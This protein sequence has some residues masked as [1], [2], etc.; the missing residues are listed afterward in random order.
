MRHA[1]GRAGILALAVAAVAIGAALAIATNGRAASGNIC[2]VPTTTTNQWASCVKQFVLPHFIA[3]GKSALS[4]TKFT[5]ESGSGG[6]TATHLVLAVDLG[7]SPGNVSIVPGTIQLYLNGVALAT[8]GCTTPTSTTTGDLVLSCPVGNV[9][10]GGVA[11]MVVEVTTA[12]NLQLVGSA[13][14]GE[15]PGNPS[16]PPNDFQQNHDF[17]TVV[18]DG[19]A[20]G[21]CFT[22]AWNLSGTTAQQQTTAAGGLGNDGFPCTFADAGVHASIP[23]GFH[24]FVSFVEFPVLVG[25]PANV[26]ILFTP[27]PAPLKWNTFPLYENN[28]GADFVVPNCNRD[29]SVPA[30]FDSCIYNRSTLPKGGAEVDLHVTGSPGDGNYWG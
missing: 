4:V 10:G 19:S 17:L 25:A 3:P 23:A 21:S 5:N 9:A 15:G 16:N 24:T 20:T 11:K 14:Y 6:A 7:A 8:G 1:R 26:A 30:G 13:S 18:G 22:A 12:Q 2:N 27:L 28:G 29:G